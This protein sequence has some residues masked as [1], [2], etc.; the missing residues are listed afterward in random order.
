MTSVGDAVDAAALDPKSASEERVSYHFTTVDG[1]ETDVS[2][3]A[4]ATVYDACAAASAWRGLQVAR[5]RL[6][7]HG[8]VEPLPFCRKT[9]L[10][11]VAGGQTDLLVVISRAY[12]LGEAT[13]PLAS[14]CTRCQFE[15]YPS[16]LY[17]S[18]QTRGDEIEMEVCEGQRVSFFDY[19][20]PE[21]GQTPAGVIFGVSQP[22]LS[23]RMLM[24]VLVHQRRWALGIGIGSAQADQSQDPE[25]D[26]G[27]LGL[28]HG[29]SSTN[30][31]AYA[32]RVHDGGWVRDRG[33]KKFWTE[34]TEL[35]IL[36]NFDEGTMQ[37]FE[38]L[39]P[40]GKLVPIVSDSYWPTVVLFT[41][42]DAASI[43]V[44]FV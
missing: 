43:A 32:E 23:G 3:S 5:L 12:D 8:Q 38:G 42:D 21:P 4:E 28:Y 2:L 16:S 11:D 25:N 6:V 27:F 22:P 41:P 19:P 26:P 18:G 17:V 10:C 40:F 20:G 36:F 37:C 34:E 7:A 44:D 39:E 9:K 1:S 33:S 35:A 13:G 15:H 31:C 30:V 14:S 24:R 29:G